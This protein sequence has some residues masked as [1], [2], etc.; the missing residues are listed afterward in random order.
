[1]NI[2]YAGE[3]NY[4]RLSGF[5]V[6][7][8]VIFLCPEY[9]FADVT[10]TIPG[11][12]TLETVEKLS[13]DLPE[14]AAEKKENK[15]DAEAD[16]LNLRPVIEFKVDKTKKS[17]KDYYKQKK[18]EKEGPVIVD[19]DTFNAGIQDGDTGKLPPLEIKGLVWGTEVPQAIIN[20]KVLK[21]GDTINEV[22]I[23]T[24]DKTGVGVLFEGKPAK[25]ASPSK[26]YLVNDTATVPEGG[27][28]EK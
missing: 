24:I 28:N 8:A 12:T 13:K 26:S 15:Q 27:K 10:V 25:V 16:K 9:N 19:K 22:K 20:G 7:L 6:F 11:N 14:S 18:R 1:M 5:A 4:F 2:F 3:R 21:I 17:F 23:V